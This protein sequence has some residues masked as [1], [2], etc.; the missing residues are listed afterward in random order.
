MSPRLQTSTPRCGSR[1]IHPPSSPVHLEAAV[2][3]LGEQGEQPV[4]GV[5]ADAPL[6]VGTIGG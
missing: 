5:L 1:A 3:I 2:M 4:V 6:L